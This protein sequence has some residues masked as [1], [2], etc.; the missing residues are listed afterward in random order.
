MSKFVQIRRDQVV[1]I[2]PCA[3]DPAYWPDIVE[4]EDDDPRYVAFFTKIQ[5][6]LAGLPDGDAG[7]TSTETPNQNADQQP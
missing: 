6:I 7:Q 3:Q 1:T 5:A 4:V 2:S